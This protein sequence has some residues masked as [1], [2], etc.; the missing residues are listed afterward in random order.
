MAAHEIGWDRQKIAYN[1][2]LCKTQSYVL[3]SPL[4]VG[5]TRLVCIV[6]VLLAETLREERCLKHKSN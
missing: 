2:E 1:R 4:P 6:F 3:H 5:L